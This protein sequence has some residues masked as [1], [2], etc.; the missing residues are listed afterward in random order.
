MATAAANI[1]EPD[2]V[3]EDQ[4]T[5]EAALVEVFQR[6]SRNF[7]LAVLPQ[8]EQR[9]LAL[10]ARRFVSIPGAQWE[11]DFGAAFDNA[12]KLEINLT[13]DG[14]EKIYR[15][16]NENRIVPD[17]RPAGGKGDEVSAET[18]AGLHRADG[19]CYKS[20]QARDNAFIEGAAG[21]FGAYRLTNEWADPYDKDSDAQRINPAYLIAD[22][23]QRVFFD[24]DSKLYDKSDAKYAF[25]ITAKSRETFEEEYPDG[26]SD[27]GV[28][29]IDPVFDWFTPDIVKIAEYYE[30]VENDEKLLIL[31]HKLSGEE[32]RYWETEISDE[33]VRQLKK[34]GWTVKSRILKRRRVHKYVMSGEEVLADKGLIAGDRI[35]IVPYYGKR[36][37]VDGVERFEGYVQGKMDVQRLY[38]M[39][40]SKLAE[41]SAQSP[42]QIPIFAAQ[43]MPPN[44]ADLWSR[45]L[46]ERHAYAV[47]EPLIDPVSGSIVSAGPIGSVPPA[48]VDPATAAVIQ[49]ARNDLTADQ[50]DGSDTV[51]ANTSEEAMAFAAT[52]VD[53]KSGIYLDNWAHTVQCEGEIYVS[54][55]ADVYY[56]PSREI[57]TMEE[58]GSD[59]T[60]TLLQ[61]YT[62][63]RTGPGYLNDFSMGN[64]KVVVEV[65][66]A[67]ATRREKTVKS[68]VA[69]AA[70][71]AELVPALGQAALIT[72]V[73]NMDGEGSS[74]LQKYARKLGIS[75]GMIEPTDDEKTEMA[76]AAQ[77]EAQQPPSPEEQ[78][79]AAK[80]AETTASAHD[81]TAD[82]ILKVTQAK[83][84]GS[85]GNVTPDS[86]IETIGKLADAHKDMAEA[87]Q[88]ATETAH[89]PQKLAIE[90]AN[91]RTNQ[92]K[93]AEAG[94]L[95]RFKALFSRGGTNG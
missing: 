11:G 56:E 79:A 50:Q 90:A 31:N 2:D 87:R 25:V 80:I 9:S 14:L 84:I 10:V 67:T 36:S 32:D 54:M 75:Q 38:N 45:Q 59:G 58:D 65:T 15:D 81:K 95:A 62:D 61:Q 83:Q 8:L 22:A 44:L 37:F 57:E 3:L 76:Q 72:A 93:V 5:G 48:Q 12:I 77:T 6:A 33:E 51:K 35:P 39:A 94:R 52:R 78:L 13:K 41:T 69:I 17:F 42:R 28:P 60:A 34:M 46:V 55:A 27:W 64:Y 47:V 43:Q 18:L 30:V 91:A 29:R 68:C 20:Q 74:D 63:P 26:M 73:A 19:Y 49:V 4:E 40:V 21:G 53:A 66:E 23:D 88:I 85:G 89:L 86:P 1:N 92:M 7:D 82:A 70:A 16:Y 24:P 71:A